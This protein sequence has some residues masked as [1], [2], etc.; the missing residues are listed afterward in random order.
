VQSKERSREEHVLCPNNPELIKV[1]STSEFGWPRRLCH[2]LFLEPIKLHA[3]E[4]KE[5]LEILVE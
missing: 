4:S 2:L 5:K 1:R 3:N